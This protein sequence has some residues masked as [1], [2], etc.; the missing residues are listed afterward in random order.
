VPIVKDYGM[1]PLHPLAPAQHM[2]A[3]A[4]LPRENYQEPEPVTAHIVSHQLHVPHGQRLHSGAHQF[5]GP[6][7]Q[8][9]GAVLTPQE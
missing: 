1:S 9:L 4:H 2:Q 8:A 6:Q 5:H 3:K 7:H